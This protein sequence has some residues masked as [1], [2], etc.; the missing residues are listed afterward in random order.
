M[1]EYIYIYIYIYIHIYIAEEVIVVIRAFAEG[2]SESERKSERR[3]FVYMARM[4]RARFS[5]PSVLLLLR[6]FFY[7]FVLAVRI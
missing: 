2:E 5:F 3:T 1:C 7:L 4:I 6:P